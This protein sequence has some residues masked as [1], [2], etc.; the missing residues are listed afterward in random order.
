MI[1][2]SPEAKALGASRTMA[3]FLVQEK[4]EALGMKAFSSN[5]REYQAMN[6]RI[7]KILARY[8]PRLET[9]SIDECWMDMSGLADL[10]SLVP[11]LIKEIK[12]LTGIQMRIGVAPTKTL[13]KIAIHLA[14]DEPDNC[15]IIQPQDIQK[16]LQRVA[17][18]DIWNIGSKYAAMLHRNNIHTAAQLALAPDWWVRKKMT[19]IGWRTLQELNGMHVLKLVEIMDP[20]KNI[21]VGRSF[22]KMTADRQTLTDAATFYSFRLS[23]KLREEKQAATVITVKLRTNKHKRDMAQHQPVR[24][25]HLDK[26]ISNILDITRYARRGIESIMDENEK[27][28]A[29]Y[30]YM[31]FEINAGGLIPADESQL[32]I[33]DNYSAGK[34]NRLSRVID[35][36]NLQLGKGKVCFANNLQAWKNGTAETYIMRQEYSSPH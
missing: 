30:R 10:P 23:E 15:L 31:K 20:K 1:A 2:L 11:F 14:K 16:E 12:Q 17:V 34:K 35:E 36:L 29:D 5:Y 21:G 9:Y 6:K 4:Y 24:T 27:G 33:G 26:A 22:K 3:W 28:G 32:L 18:E 13:A 7:M 19:V 25:Y 8:V